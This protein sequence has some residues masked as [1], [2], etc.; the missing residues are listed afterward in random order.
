[1]IGNTVLLSFIVGVNRE[2]GEKTSYSVTENH[3]ANFPWVYLNIEFLHQCF[4]KVLPWWMALQYLSALVVLL[5]I[6]SGLTVYHWCVHQQYTGR[7]TQSKIKAP[8]H[9]NAVQMLHMDA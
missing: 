3:I 8:Y 2:V 6:L 1:M 9:W 5:F 4:Y 7:V